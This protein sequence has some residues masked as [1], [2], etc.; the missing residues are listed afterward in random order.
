[1]KAKL[2]AI[3]EGD[4][5]AYGHLVAVLKQMILNN[6]QDGYHLF[7][8]YSQNVKHNVQPT[9]PFRNQESDKLQEYAKKARALLNK[10]NVGTEEEPQEP[11][12]CGY[13]S[14]LMEESKIFEK[15]GVGFGEEMTYII[16]KAL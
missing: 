11:G 4:S 1:M 2:E 15:A 16:F 6:D 9:E 8:Y 14:N 12:P 3:K 13:L 7:E 5:N 10:P